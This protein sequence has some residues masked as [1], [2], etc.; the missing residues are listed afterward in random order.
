MADPFLALFEQFLMIWYKFGISARGAL[1]ECS[2]CRFHGTGC[3][4]LPRCHPMPGVW[5]FCQCHRGA[6]YYPDATRCQGFGHSA[7]ATGVPRNTPMPP[8]ARGLT[9]LQG[10]RWRK[11]AQKKGS[12]IPRLQTELRYNL[13]RS[14]KTARTQAQPW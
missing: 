11:A 14:Q 12:G 1:P 3:H 6:T 4:V 9:I 7:S 13:V 2:T 10:P 5:P 8:D